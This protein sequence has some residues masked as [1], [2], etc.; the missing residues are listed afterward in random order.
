MV[1]LPS[2]IHEELDRERIVSGYAKPRPKRPYG[3][4]ALATAFARVKD[5]R[6]TAQPL[7]T[8]SPSETPSTNCEKAP[9]RRW[10]FW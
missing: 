10:L 3:V 4:V 5:W 6:P 9:T 2:L 7:P 1:L 8:G